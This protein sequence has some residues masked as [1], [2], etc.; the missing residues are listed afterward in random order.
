MEKNLFILVKT[1]SN[2]FASELKA[3]KEIKNFEFILNHQAIQE[4]L[5]KG[6]VSSPKT[7]YNDIYKLE[8]GSLAIINNLNNVKIK[9]W[10]S[11]NNLKS[12]D[13]KFKS[14]AKK[15]K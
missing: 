5:A 15:Y 1:A 4:M 12:Y 13:A 6:Y 2:F 10:W 11:L 3:I 7:I 14:K 8:P 9:N